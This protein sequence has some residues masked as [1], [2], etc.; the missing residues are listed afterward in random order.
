VLKQFSKIAL[1]K[2]DLPF[3]ERC[4]KEALKL[5]QNIEKNCWDGNWYLRA[6]FDDGQLLG[7]SSNHE[8]QIDSVSQSWSV[9]SGA[10]D[11]ERSRLA[12]EAFNKHLVRR[13]DGIIQLLNPPFDKSDMNP[14]YIKGYVPGVRENGGQYTHAA[15]WAAMAYANMGDNLHAWELLNIINPVKHAVSPE[16][17]AK[18]KVEPYVV[19]ADVYALSPHIGHGGWTWYTGSA[20]LMYRLIIESLLGLRLEVDILYIEPRLPADWKKLNITYRYKETNYLISIMQKYDDHISL[21]ITVDGKIL[22]DSSIHLAD[23]KMEHSAEVLISLQ[24]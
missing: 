18:Y 24:I 19:A 7:S 14:G 20:G 1:I 17:V 5:R 6:W 3:A 15:I 2:E 12:M 10:G 22:S 23:D 8:C 21:Q 13:E 16:G 9:L 11:P 4:K